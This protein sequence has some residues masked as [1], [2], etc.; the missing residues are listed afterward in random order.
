MST[1]KQILF[2]WFGMFL[3]TLAQG[4]EKEAF[5]IS[6]KVLD[7]ESQE[8]VPM[9][10]VIIKNKKKGTNGDSEG[11]FEVPVTMGDQIEITSIGYEPI[12][13]MVT[14]EFTAYKEEQMILFMI[15]KVYELDSVVVI[16][17]GEDF[18]LRRKKG[19]PIEIIGLPKPTDNPRDWSKPQVVADGNGVG[20]YGLLNAFDK[21]LQQKI[22]VRKLQAAIDKDRERKAQAAAKYNRQIVKEIT[23]IDDRV[24]EEFMEFCNFKEHEIILYS[25]YEITT[26]LLKHYHA[27]LRR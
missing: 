18:Y 13:F 25:E 15:P 20:L 12:E 10:H 19:K 23:G 24:I 5:V 6:G 17:L 2:I 3:A 26:R 27:F 1:V 21:E 11:N 16:H 22:K 4:Q 8:G 7:A 9:V 14:E